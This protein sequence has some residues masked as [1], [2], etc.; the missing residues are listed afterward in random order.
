MH[1]SMKVSKKRLKHRFSELAFAE[2]PCATDLTFWRS[3]KVSEGLYEQ[4][5]ISCSGASSEAVYAYFTCAV[6]N[7]GYPTKGLLESRLVTEIATVKE[8][9]WTIISSDDDAR[10]WEDSLID[11]IYSEFG[12]F[13]ESVASPLLETTASARSSA[14]EYV[15][16][17]NDG[18]VSAEART[19]A[20]APGICQV[21]GRFDLYEQAASC[22]LEH[23]AMVEKET[24]FDFSRPL[25]DLQLLWRLQLIVS[26]VLQKE[27][28]GN[29]TS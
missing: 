18:E 16:R 11:A 5:R 4:V 7:H 14:Q 29:S 27:I 26:Q 20:N 13:V 1:N 10:I 15:S 12:E 19:I 9:G 17:L 23:H 6:V 28:V 24:S 8:R 21:P 3:S 2:H 25:F 22:I